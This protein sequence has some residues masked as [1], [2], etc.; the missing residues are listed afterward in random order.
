ME[1]DTIGKDTEDRSEIDLPLRRANLVDE[2][3]KPIPVAPA[4]VETAV[5]A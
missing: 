5:A 3:G 1:E 2:Q 4:I